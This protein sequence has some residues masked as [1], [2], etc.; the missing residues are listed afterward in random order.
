MRTASISIEDVMF[1]AKQLAGGLVLIYPC[2][3]L[4][5]YYR[6]GLGEEDSLGYRHK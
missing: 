5:I 3:A 4:P 2:W 1:H 6:G